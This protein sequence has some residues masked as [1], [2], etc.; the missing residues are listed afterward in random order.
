[1]NTPAFTFEAVLEAHVRGGCF[2]RVPPAVT[3][4]LGTRGQVRVQ[5][6]LNG[7]EFASSLAPMGGGQHALLVHKATR[8]ALGIAPG[9]TAVVSIRPDMAERLVEVPAELAEALAATPPAGATFAAL[10]Y[11][12]RKEYA[13]WIAEA[14]KPATRTRRV[15]K[16]VAMLLAGQKIS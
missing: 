14:K 5:G 4:A 11:T 13:G 16:A 9:S 7:Y 2:C 12:H 10:A 1:M 6:T 8:T 3:A 15:A